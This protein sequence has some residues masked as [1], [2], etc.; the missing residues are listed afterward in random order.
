MQESVCLQ[1]NKESITECW[2]KSSP[3]EQGRLEILK[4]VIQE[5]KE[6]EL[7]NPEEQKK[8]GIEKDEYVVCAQFYRPAPPSYLENI[9]IIPTII[10]FIILLLIVTFRTDAYN[11]EILNNCM[12]YNI[13]NFI[14]IIPIMIFFYI[15][16]SYIY[17]SIFIILVTNKNIYH[18][19]NIYRIDYHNQNF[20]K[21]L[22]DGI[23]IK[24]S[25]DSTNNLLED[26]FIQYMEIP[27]RLFF[28]KNNKVLLKIDTGIYY[29]YFAKKYKISSL[30]T[31]AAYINTI[32]ILNV[33][34]YIS[35]VYN[36]PLYIYPIHCG[37]A[38]NYKK[39]I[40]GQLLFVK[41][42]PFKNYV[43]LHKDIEQRFSTLTDLKRYLTKVKKLSGLNKEKIISILQKE[44][45]TKKE[46][47]EELYSIPAKK[48]LLGRK[49]VIYFSK[50]NIWI[51]RNG[52]MIMDKF[53][54]HD[55]NI[56]DSHKYFVFTFKEGSIVFFSLKKN[57]NFPLI[58]ITELFFYK[59]IGYADSKFVDWES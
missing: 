35:C 6:K 32:Y 59:K 51:E 29:P 43:K 57:I 4:Q 50:K 13:L 45:L 55:V 27:L 28:I 56:Y 36:I 17:K 9:I 30:R 53:C 15:K 31:G 44:P 23:S 58:D 25:I 14:L 48:S 33:L 11:T 19:Y 49:Y 22:I 10:A 20:K 1:E 37:F 21:M 3:F 24:N 7:Y 52:K 34:A 18:S 54:F 41:E 40:F 46:L 26:N 47:D 39:Y 42:I 5:G 8:F 16:S 2:K 12:W 38:C